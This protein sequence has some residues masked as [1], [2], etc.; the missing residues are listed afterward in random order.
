MTFNSWLVGFKHAFEVKHVL[1]A[2]LRCSWNRHVSSCSHRTGE[3]NTFLIW[4]WKQLGELHW[5]AA[6]FIISA[7]K[8]HQ[9][10][11]INA[12]FPRLSRNRNDT[13]DWSHK[14]I[15]CFFY[16]T[17]NF[18]AWP[19]Q[20]IP[21]THMGSKVVSLYSRLRTYL[22]F[23]FFFPNDFRDILI[24]AVLSWFSAGLVGWRKTVSSAIAFGI[25]LL[26]CSSFKSS[27]HD[28][29]SRTYDFILGL[30]LTVTK[31]NTESLSE[32]WIRPLYAFYKTTSWP[33]FNF[34]DFFFVYLECW[35]C[36]R[37]RWVVLPQFAPSTL[38]SAVN[39]HF[40]ALQGK[41]IC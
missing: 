26:L 4:W 37:G 11:G 33:L 25:F 35:N 22:F 20:V 40:L 36:E 5:N 39:V 27:S 3:S 7:L 38:K 19:C 41:K 24:L 32:I 10:H 14:R 6:P 9:S 8:W 21:A 23:F 2:T 1:T 18:G 34:L 31:I 29:V 30:G 15:L 12:S 17:W 28:L 13:S 16:L